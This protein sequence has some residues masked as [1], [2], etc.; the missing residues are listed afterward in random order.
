MFCSSCGAQVDD[1]QKFCSGCGAA[2]SP[3]GA[4]QQ[5]AV[6]PP[7]P[8]AP[9]PS[10]V[11]PQ[12]MIQPPP[13]PQQAMQPPPAPQQSYQQPGM[14][15]QKPYAAGMGQPMDAGES[16]GGWI[17]AG[18]IFGVLGGLIGLAIGSY[19]WS[20]KIQTPQG[21]IHKFNKS[22]RTHGLIILVISG[23]MMALWTALNQ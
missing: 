1:G 19:L 2:V 21:K 5:T 13:A 10:Q 14:Q 18:Y 17:I 8:P 12:P 4:A 7:P 16:G 3:Q 6:P 9:A 20:T 23:F 22:T 15:P 11:P